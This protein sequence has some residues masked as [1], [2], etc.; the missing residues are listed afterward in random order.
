MRG[1][2]RP[3]RGEH[4]RLGRLWCPQRLP[5]RQEPNRPCP[6]DVLRQ[7][8]VVSWHIN[9]DGYAEDAQYQAIR[10]VRG[11]TYEDEIDIH[12]DR[13]PGYEAKLKIFFEEHIHADEEIRYVLDG[14]GYFDV[15]DAEDRWIR[16][17]CQKG[18]M[19]VLPAGIW[20][21]FTLDEGNYIKAKRLFVGEPVWTPLNRS[22][23]YD[24]HP[25]RVAYV[26]GLTVA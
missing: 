24:S 5:H 21:R 6:V 20:H 1:E 2:V 11:Y 19:I 15:R 3:Q 23:N 12:K 4:H 9:P 16:I 14:S 8:G 18:D 22:D 13:L 7:L 10:K 25:A 26:Q 17:S